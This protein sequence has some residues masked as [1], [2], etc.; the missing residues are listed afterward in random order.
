MIL[1]MIESSLY[2]DELFVVKETVFVVKETV[3]GLKC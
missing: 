2:L 1:R 3:L